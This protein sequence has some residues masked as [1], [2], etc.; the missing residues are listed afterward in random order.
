MFG[1]YIETFLRIQNIGRSILRPPGPCGPGGLQCADGGRSP[2]DGLNGV[3]WMKIAL[4]RL[5]STL[6]AEGIQKISQCDPNSP[7]PTVAP[8]QMVNSE[9]SWVCPVPGLVDVWDLH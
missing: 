4:L 8:E 5:V 3:P 7:V 2:C 6:V 9:V 1:A